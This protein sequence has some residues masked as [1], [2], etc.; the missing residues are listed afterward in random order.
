MKSAIS[1]L[2]AQFCL[3]FTLGCLSP[4]G[5]AQV[6][7]T[8]VIPVPTVTM[9]DQE[10]LA[11][12]EGGRP[13]TIAGELRLPKAGADRLPLVMLLHGSGGIGSSVTDW[14]QDLLG[15]GVAT[16]VL[17]SF[18]ARGITSTINDQTQLPRLAQ[19]EDAF[20][21]LAI[22]SR[23]PRI[24]PTRIMLVGFSRGGQNALYA[25]L[26]RFH[27]LH[28]SPGTEFA[29]YVAFY[30]DCSY[31]YRE[32]DDLVAK[33]LRILQ[34]SADN[35]DPVGPCRAYVDRLKAKGNDAMLIEYPKANHAFDSR[36]LASAVQL[37]RAQTTRHCRTVE[38]ENGL[39]VNAQTSKPFTYD[40]PCVERGV[41]VAYDEQAAREARQALHELVIA[42]LKPGAVATVTRP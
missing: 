35:Y 1:Y 37:P 9:S 11:G 22:L 40:D 42:V 5:L 15:M 19:M 29:A 14:E 18:S 8:E 30:P 23:H 4:D 6:V 16:F 34:G 26:K 21:A 20:R 31:T 13:A 12:V 27:R 25:S 2:A 33:P 3:L 24:D 7:R 28:A 32:D 36:A 17:D 10:F 39:L 38:L 41:T